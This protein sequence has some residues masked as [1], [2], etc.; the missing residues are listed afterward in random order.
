LLALGRDAQTLSEAGVVVVTFNAEG[1]VD[2]SPEDILSEGSEDYNGFRHQDSLCALVERTMALPYVIA[3]NVGISTQSYGITMAAGCVSRHPE[4]KVKYI[5][6]GEGPPNSFVTCH[7]ARTL[8]ADPSNDKHEIVYDILGH[9]SLD[10]DPS[11]ANQDFWSEREAER[12]IGDF[13]GYYLRLQAQ[14]DHAQPPDGPDDLAAFHQP[15]TWWHN[16]HTAVI[17]NAAVEGGVPWVRVNF[18]EQGNPVNQTYDVNH[19][20]V[21]LPG[22]LADRPWGVMGI[23]EMAR[24]D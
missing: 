24:M 13:H 16:K 23:I 5:V 9:Y 20:P 18:P 2:S 12:F 7:E 22:Y 3:E 1:R 10:R 4:V 8:D 17:V 11:Q 19:M 15:P 21:F 14:W 6:D